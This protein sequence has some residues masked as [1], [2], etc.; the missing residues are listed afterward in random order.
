[1]TGASEAIAGAYACVRGS[2]GT[3]A[4][5]RKVGGFEIFKSRK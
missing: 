4:D 1:M 3:G 2:T 5:R